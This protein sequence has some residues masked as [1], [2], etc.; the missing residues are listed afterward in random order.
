MEDHHPPPL[1]D[2]ETEARK[3]EATRLRT[4]DW[5]VADVETKQRPQAS[6]PGTSPPKPASSHEDL[7]DLVWE[8]LLTR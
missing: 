3:Q 2:G 4:P 7:H 1:L 8:L 5:A 6:F